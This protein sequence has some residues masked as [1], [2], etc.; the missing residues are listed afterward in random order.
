MTS[1][2]MIRGKRV[3]RAVWLAPPATRMWCVRYV[4]RSERQC[5]HRVYFSMARAFELRSTLVDLGYEVHVYSTDTT[6]KESLCR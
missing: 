6:W 4:Q 3:P 5:G 1:Y 2:R